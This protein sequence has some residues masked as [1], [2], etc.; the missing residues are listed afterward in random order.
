[1]LAYVKICISVKKEVFICLFVKIVYILE[2]VGLKASMR[3]ISKSSMSLTRN[4]IFLKSIPSVQSST[5]EHL[6]SINKRKYQTNYYMM[7]I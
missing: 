6:K 3:I 1:M 7:I 2:Y 5:V 4:M